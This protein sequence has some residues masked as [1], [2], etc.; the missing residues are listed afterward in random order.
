MNDDSTPPHKEQLVDAYLGVVESTAQA[1]AETS[2]VDPPR[3]WRTHRLVPIVLVLGVGILGYIWLGKPAWLFEPD[4]PS[5][6]TP[7]QQQATLR[8]GLYLQA[9]RVREFLREN[10]RLPE[11]LEETGEVEDGV[12][13]RKTGDTTFVVT[14]SLDTTVLTLSSTESA[15]NFLKSTEI[16]IAPT[17]Q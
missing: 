15:A 2:Q 12:S 4:A 14:A 10:G 17:G 5:V 11:N 8:F 3:P 1:S 7:A 6:S 13:Y 9:E 16:R